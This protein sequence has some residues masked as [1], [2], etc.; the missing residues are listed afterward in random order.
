MD[1]GDRLHNQ[2]AIALDELREKEL[3]KKDAE[4]K[5]DRHQDGDG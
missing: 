1:D 4:N 3:Y 2:K 5:G